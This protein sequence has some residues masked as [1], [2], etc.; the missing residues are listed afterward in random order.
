MLNWMHLRGV[1]GSPLNLQVQVVKLAVLEVKVNV[2]T[3]NC[4]FLIERWE[5]LELFN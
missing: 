2:S 4:I 3:L 1:S 5:F